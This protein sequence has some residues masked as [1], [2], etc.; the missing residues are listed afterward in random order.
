MFFFYISKNCFSL[1]KLKKKKFIIFFLL[2]SL[3]DGTPNTH[4]RRA[5][6]LVERGGVVTCVRDGQSRQAPAAAH[7][8]LLRF[9]QTIS[10]KRA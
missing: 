2:I 1:K 5:T 4:K 10:L 7:P 9:Q 6:L 3:L 8:N